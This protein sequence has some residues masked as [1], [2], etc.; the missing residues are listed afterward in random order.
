MSFYPDA[1]LKMSK[2]W[3]VW[4]E[5]EFYNKRYTIKRVFFVFIFLWTLKF[6]T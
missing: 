6:F 3:R 4:L 5:C 2:H 1:Q